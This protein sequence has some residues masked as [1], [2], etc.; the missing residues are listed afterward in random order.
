MANAL[1][2]FVMSLVRDPEAAARYS[3]D[4]ERAIAEA[5]LSGVTSVDVSSLIPV[6]SE[7]M[8]TAPGAGI[9]GGL[10]DAGLQSN[11]WA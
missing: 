7:S 5:Q 4:P 10:E 9:G 3:A 11:V 2:D 8:P 1:L 6:V